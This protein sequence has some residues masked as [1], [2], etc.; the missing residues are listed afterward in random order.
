MRKNGRHETRTYNRMTFY[1]KAY[2]EWVNSI[3]RNDY[4][5]LW[6]P[7]VDKIVYAIDYALHNKKVR[8]ERLDFAYELCSERGR[9]ITNIRVVAPPGTVLD[10]SLGGQSIRDADGESWTDWDALPL[11]PFASYHS[12]VMRGKL[13]R[14]GDAVTITYDTVETTDDRFDFNTGSQEWCLLSGIY[15]AREVARYHSSHLSK[16]S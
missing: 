16:T 4:Y 14:V 2:A 3:D 13:P 8:K 15:A 5:G 7:F 12:V 11:I 10:L 6:F 9:A 1:Y